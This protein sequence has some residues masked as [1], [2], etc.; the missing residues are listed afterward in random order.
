MYVEV[1]TLPG[2]NYKEHIL[3]RKM[4][5]ISNHFPN[6]YVTQGYRFQICFHQFYRSNLIKNQLFVCLK[7]LF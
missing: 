1:G 5:Q 2:C 7:Y 4:E 3:N 6:L